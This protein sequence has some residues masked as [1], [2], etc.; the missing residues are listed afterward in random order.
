MSMWQRSQIQAVPWTIVRKTLASNFLTSSHA[1]QILLLLP[2]SF[3]PISSFGF[4]VKSTTQFVMVVP[5]LSILK[6]LLST[7]REVFL[8]NQHF[9][10]YAVIGNVSINLYQKKFGK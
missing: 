5:E 3:V 1:K 2:S 4:E 10:E 6:A 7:L 9:F 8:C